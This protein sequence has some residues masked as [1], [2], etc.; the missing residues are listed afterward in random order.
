MPNTKVKK[1]AKAVA[2]TPAKKPVRRATLA[3][4]Q[5][6]MDAFTKNTD[7]VLGR[8]GNNLG[9]MME[10]MLVPNL[11][12]KFKKFGFTFQVIN[13]R[14]KIDDNE[15]DIHAE[16]DAFLENGTQAMAVEVKVTL[17]PEDISEHI[18]RMEKIRKYADLHNDKREFYAAIAAAVIAE[19]TKT[20]ALRQGFYV[21]EPSG[22]DVKITKPF[23]APK[24]W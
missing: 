14:R 22:E 6:S 1:P 4:L 16:I 7:Q 12:E 15:H 24:V 10:Y 20:A 19:D 9:D 21:I 23:S 18:K 3:D 13:R 5:A 17:R 11:P 8:L 2:K